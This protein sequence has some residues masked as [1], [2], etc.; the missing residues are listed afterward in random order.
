MATLTLEIPDDL[1]NQIKSAGHSI[2][3]IL[4]KAL[5]QYL[6]DEL[7]S[8]GIMQTRTWQLCGRFTISE[9]ASAEPLSE[10]TDAVGTTN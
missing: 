9:A 7:S 1:L 2:E 10:D 8:Q 3:A 5:T 4:P 6:A